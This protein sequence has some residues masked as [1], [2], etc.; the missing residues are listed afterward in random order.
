MS[1]QKLFPGQEYDFGV[2][3]LIIPSL[4]LYSVK[5]LEGEFL[6]LNDYAGD[7]QVEV[8]LDIIQESLQRNYPDFSRERLEQYLDLR[9]IKEVIEIVIRLSGLVPTED[10]SAKVEDSNGGK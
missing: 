8:M 7:K 6:K 2:E 5:K 3:K 10:G 4:S 9:N 1:N